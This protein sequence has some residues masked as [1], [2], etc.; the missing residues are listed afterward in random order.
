MPNIHAEIK[1]AVTT[2]KNGGL[3]ILPTDTYWSIACDAT[4][5]KAVEKLFA[6]KQSKSQRNITCFVADDRMLNKYVKQIPLAA[7][8]ILEITDTPTTLIYEAPQNLATNLIAKDNTIAIRIPD[9]DFCYQLSRR[10]N[11]ALATTLA[12]IEGETIPKSF[13]EIVPAILKDVAY[14]VNLQ[15][16]KICKIHAAIIQI[17]NSNI[18][19]ILRK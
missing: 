19:K 4:N 11:G 6:I 3:I 7:Q 15:K 8:S 13:K 12:H 14:V 1:N 2:L 17:R 10:L 9:D 5:N 18:V 16:E